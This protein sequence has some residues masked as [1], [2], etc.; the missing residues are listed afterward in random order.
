FR[1]APVAG[2]RVVLG[3]QAAGE[4]M[5]VLLALDPV[6]A[7]LQA[8]AEVT[9]GSDGA[10]DF[11][12]QPPAPF[13]V[14]ASAANYTPRAIAVANMS[15]HTKS[16]QLLLELGECGTRLFGTVADAS[17]GGIAKATISAAGL[18]G[19]QSDATGNYSLCVSPIDAFGPPLARVRVAA[20]GYGTIAQM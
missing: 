7:A 12:I 13:T 1:G 20:D 10:F 2:A 14:S 15:P 4:P 5:Q 9:S 3:L 19:T 18:S 6:P 16:D 17:G 11:G 8:I